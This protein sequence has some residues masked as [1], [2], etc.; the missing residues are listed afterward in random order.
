MSKKNKKVNNFEKEEV[1]NEEKNN[2]EENQNNNLKDNIALKLSC[3]FIDSDN[4][5]KKKFLKDIFKDLKDKTILSIMNRYLKAISDGF[6]FVAIM[7]LEQ[8]KIVLKKIDE[9]ESEFNSNDY[10]EVKYNE[11]E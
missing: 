7:E 4:S 11:E 6:Y 3:H 10:R 8:L 2:K 1:K 5:L 9:I